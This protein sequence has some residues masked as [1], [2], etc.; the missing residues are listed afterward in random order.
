MGNLS[1]NFH[2]DEFACKCGCGFDDIDLELVQELQ[3]LR[4]LISRPI[5]IRSGCR[6]AK[7]N[8]VIGGVWDSAHLVGLAVDIET[9]YSHVRYDIISHAIKSLDIN[10]IGIGKD[11]VHLDVDK[12][13]PKNVMW[14]Y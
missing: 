2:R 14:I 9:I 12:H 6:C 7:Y 8:E 13:K 11:F 1:T 10:R 3:R 4:D 5:I